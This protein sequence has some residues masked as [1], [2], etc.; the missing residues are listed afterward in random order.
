[1]KQNSESLD[2]DQRLEFTSAPA[3]GDR[4]EKISPESDESKIDRNE[5]EKQ[6]DEGKKEEDEPKPLAEEN[7][8]P[9]A[10]ETTKNIISTVKVKK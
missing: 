1:M 6:L 4:N 5:N 2:P 8:E 3:T 9:N 10:N 7:K